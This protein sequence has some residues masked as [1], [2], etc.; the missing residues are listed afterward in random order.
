MFSLLKIGSEFDSTLIRFV[1]SHVQIKLKRL[2]LLKT[3]IRFKVKH[4]SE[5]IDNTEY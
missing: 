3:K 5:E 4:L 1:I 2:K